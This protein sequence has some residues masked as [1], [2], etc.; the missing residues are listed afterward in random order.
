[1]PELTEIT[2]ETPAKIE[3]TEARIEDDDDDDSD[4]TIP[5]LEDTGKW[6]MLEA[7]E[8]IALSRNIWSWF[9]LSF[10]Y[11]AFH[12]RQYGRSFRQRCWRSSRFGVKGKTIAWREKSPQNYVEIGLETGAR[13]Q[14]GH[15]S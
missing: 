7:R 3:E 9:C 12:C 14:S 15:N 5:E 4:T 11:S 13:C 6:S 2:N 8:I 10:F 1:M